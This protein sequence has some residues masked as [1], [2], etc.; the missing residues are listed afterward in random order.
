MT[1]IIGSQG[2]MGKR[3]QAILNHL[4]EP[5]G[6]YD[7]A[8]SVGFSDVKEI[9]KYDRFIVATPTDT[10]KYWIRFLDEHKK[11]ILCEKPLS[12]KKE[13][14]DFILS[15]KSDLSM[16]AQYEYFTDPYHGNGASWYNFYNHGKDGIVWDCFQVVALA[17]EKFDLGEDSPVWS[18][19]L[20]GKEIDLRKMDLAYV[21]AVKNFL[22]GRYLQRE[23]LRDWHDKVL[24]VAKK[25]QS[26]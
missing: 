21:W 11:P 23:K 6:R 3:Y 10:H 4:N 22:A 12:T 17:K 25:W 7:T 9:S 13:D 19:G 8:L 5:F 1:L 18:A 20:N 2:S 14:I 15:C 16:M 26:T 24:E